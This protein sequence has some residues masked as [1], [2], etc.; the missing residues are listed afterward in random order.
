MIK[1]RKIGTIQ[2][3]IR[4]DRVTKRSG[5]YLANTTHNSQLTERTDPAQYYEF[6]GGLGRVK[7]RDRALATEPRQI[8][9]DF[10]GTR[11]KNHNSTGPQP[12]DLRHRYQVRP[13]EGIQV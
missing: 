3:I 10:K 7:D 13:V 5:Q 12:L 4:T 11:K 9:A 2:E 6:T 8:A 1:K